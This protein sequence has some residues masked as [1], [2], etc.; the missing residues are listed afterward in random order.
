[1]IVPYNKFENAPEA[2]HALDYAIISIGTYDKFSC[3]R[4]KPGEVIEALPPKER[5]A[6]KKLTSEMT[7]RQRFEPWM[8]ETMNTDLY[9]LKEAMKEFDERIEHAKSNRINR[10]F[11]GIHSPR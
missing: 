6:I 8:A 2:L 11:Y 1:M 7:F 4:G 3:H 10:R 5:E 9:W